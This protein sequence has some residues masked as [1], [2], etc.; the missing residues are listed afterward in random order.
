M[1]V[2]GLI[3]FKQGYCW[4]GPSGPVLDTKRKMRGSLV[5]D[6]CYQMR[7]HTKLSNLDMIKADALFRDIC[8]QDGLRKW[9][10]R[11]Y[12]IGLR[13]FGHKARSEAGQREIK[14]AP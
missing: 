10:A 6:G 12:Y 13:N 8:I 14:T 9:R 11:L 7:R 4:D 3:T 5:H 2:G 1:T